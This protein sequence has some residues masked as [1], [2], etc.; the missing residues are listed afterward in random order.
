VLKNEYILLWENERPQEIRELTSKGVIPVMHDIEQASASGV[1]TTPQQ[2]LA[3]RPLLMGQAAGAISD[4]KPAQDIINEMVADAIA[5][6]RH[7][8]GS[9]TS[10]KANL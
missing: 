9:V 1:E 2:T 4:I 3:Y 8:A 6:L 10:F 7:S 5:A